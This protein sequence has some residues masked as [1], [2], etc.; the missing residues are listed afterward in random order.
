[1]RG[2]R[3]AKRSAFAECWL[4]VVAQVL[5]LLLLLASCVLLRQ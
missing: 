2:N 1:M 4:V 5:L 3:S